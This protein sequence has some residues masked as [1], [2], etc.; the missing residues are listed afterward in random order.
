MLRRRLTYS[1]S[2]QDEPQMEEE[3]VLARRQPRA[4]EDGR[5]VEDRMTLPPLMDEVGGTSM[6]ASHGEREGRMVRAVKK[7]ED[8]RS[9]A[10]SRDEEGGKKERERGEREVTQEEPST[11]T[12]ARFSMATPPS[13][14]QEPE[15]SEGWMERPTGVP[16]ILGPV[17]D[18]TY[19]RRMEEMQNQ[20]PLIYTRKAEEQLVQGLRPEFLEEERKK[21]EERELRKR[22]EDLAEENVKLRDMMKDVE[23]VIQ[24]NSEMRSQVQKMKIE[25]EL[26][27]G[28]E[29]SVERAREKIQFS[30]PEEPTPAMR[31]IGQEENPAN[32]PGKLKPEIQPDAVQVMLTLMQGMQEMQKKI[33]EREEKG[34]EGLSMR[35]VEFVR[36][37]PELPKL[38][39]WAAGTAPIDLNDWLV[40]I[41]PIMADLTPTSQEW[42][43][44]LLQESREWYDHHMSKTPMERLSHEPS[45]SPDLARKRWSRLE[46]RAST[47]LLMGIPEAQR[48]ELIA[49]KRV[50]AKGIICRLLTVYQPGGLAEKEV[51]LRSLEAPAEAVSLPEAVTGLRKWMRW[52]NRARELGVSEP[53]ASILLRGLGK[54]VKKPLE[55][56]RDLSFRVN[57]TRSML[58]VDSTPSSTNVHQFATHL[59]A[60]MEMLAHTEGAKKVG[61]AREVPKPV[62]PRIKKTEV[63][64]K[65]N[66]KEGGREGQLPCRFFNTD[67]GCRK[68]KECRWSHVVEEGKRRCWVC[69]AVDHF[70]GACTR[71]REGKGAGDG[72][73][74]WGKGEGKSVQKAEAESPPKNGGGEASV[75]D[76]ESVKS[77]ESGEVMKNLLEEA[78]RMLRGIQDSKGEEGSEKEARIR[79][80]QRQLDELKAIRVFRIA[81]LSAGSGHGLLDSGA[82]HSLRGKHRADCMAQMQEV[83][84]NLACGR[85]TM[86]RMTK[87]GTMVA[88]N[89]NTEPI[90]PLG[91]IVDELGC[92]VG[93]GPEGITVIHPRRGRLEVYEKDGCPHVAQDVALGLIEELEEKERRKIRMMTMDD[94]E[95]EK[96]WI[97]ELVDV[98]PAL[99]SLPAEVKRSLVVKP[100]NDLKPL[101]GLNKRGRKRA[102]RDGLV[103]HLYAGPKEGFTLSR[104]A[105]EVGA[106]ENQILEVD[107]VRGDDHDMLQEAPYN[108]LLRLALDG[109]LVGLVGG[110]NCR[111]R[112]VLRHYPIEGVE[113]GGPRPLRAWGGEE[114]GKKDLKPEE[115]IR[116]WEDDVLMWR[117][118]ILYII[119]EHVK[120]ASREE[121]EEGEDSPVWFGMEQPANPTYKPEV[122]SIWET[123]QWKKLQEVYQ[124]STWT[125]NQGDWGAEAVK[126]TTWG[127]NLPLQLPQQRNPKAKSRGEEGGSKDS[128]R[129]A[130]W[131]QGMMRE[132]ASSLQRNVWKRDIRIKKLSWEEHLRNGHL[133]FRK[134][135]RICQ[136]ASA[137]SS[138]HRRVVGPGWV[139]P[140]RECFRLIPRG[141]WFE[142]EMWWGEWP[143][144]CWWEP[145]PGSFRRIQ[146]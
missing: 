9:S 35:G 31:E 64:E 101:P 78:N 28:P 123:S 118:I 39:D 109:N 45:P 61:A 110:P 19:V 22:V 68:G 60:E 32:P 85:D 94:E 99:I 145:S 4:L 117:M 103:V 66:K 125:F 111:T 12:P 56:N 133:P 30:T 144:F 92:R 47:M 106:Q 98:H 15:P 102:A 89:P 95:K 73:K 132:I 139:R 48:E 90:V 34:E 69:G 79:K 126:P 54:I 113:G 127:G 86:L 138:P 93:W 122:V 3:V 24:E 57:L 115:A 82:T 20:S 131:C 49:T 41:E 75:R 5:E 112:S 134:D 74:G 25:K 121:E 114:F 51:I 130:R 7:V 72:K 38:P 137:K 70:A 27:K 124:F 142:E 18:Q 80:L 17:L 42:W 16:R 8:V 116:V 104:A 36:G 83:K 91:K 55:L 50:T 1:R 141:H 40:L 120:R 88:L 65:F 108:A 77:E 26:E 71:P 53:D 44:V 37:Q 2:A 14:Q 52:R 96:K 76:G 97:E 29:R 105:K 100:S 58:Q 63:D 140:G 128:K 129:L 43:E 6:G 119:A 33:I 143:D 135:C 107:V 46:K 59:L 67:T 23:R 10:E 81:S 87:G 84:V 62:D 136:E 146:E 11:Q 13:D 21:T